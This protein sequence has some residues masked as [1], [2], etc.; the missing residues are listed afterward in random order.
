MPEYE[1]MKLYDNYSDLFLLSKLVDA[2]CTLCPQAIHLEWSCE[3]YDDLNFVSSQ[4][5]LHNSIKFVVI[6]CLD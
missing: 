2:N 5:C 1:L 4:I 3:M 6:V